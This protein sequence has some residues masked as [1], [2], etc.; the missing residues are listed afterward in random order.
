M[1]WIGD[2]YQ[3]NCCILLVPTS[4]GVVNGHCSEAMDIYHL[5]LPSVL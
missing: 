3:S 2:G 5:G 1:E 4:G